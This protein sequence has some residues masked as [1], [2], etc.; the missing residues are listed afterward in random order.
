MN[1]SVSVNVI[2]LERVDGLDGRKIDDRINSRAVGHRE[3]YEYNSF[4]QTRMN[5]IFR[6]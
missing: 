4:L 5:G 2:A 6:K 1:V 3:N